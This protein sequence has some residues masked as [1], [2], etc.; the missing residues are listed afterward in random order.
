MVREL[1][2]DEL[3]WQCPED[4]LPASSTEEV[5]PCVGIIGQQRAITALEFG[6][7]V[8]SLGFN[9]F[10]TGLT[11]TGK[12]TAIELQL[13]P[14]AE[15][16]PR[17]DDL[18]YV[19]DFDRPERPR[20][21][22]LRAGGGAVLRE[23]LDRFLTQLTESLPGLFESEEY[24]RR[25]ELALED[26]KI[27]QQELVRAFEEEVRAHG[28]TLVQVQVGSVTRPEILPLVEN[29][30]VTMDKVRA[31]AAEGKIDQ[32]HL[33]S[34]EKQYERLS[35]EL[36]R[37]FAQ[38]MGLRAEMVG[39]AER[40]RQD[41]LRPVLEEQMNAI[42][43]AV[44]DERVAPFLTA[45]ASD[46]LKNLEILTAKREDGSA[47]P[48]TRYRVNVVVD[49]S[50]TQGR[51]VVIETEP[52]L[53]RLFGTIEARLGQDLRSSADHTQIRAGSLLRANGGFLVLNAFDVLSESG[54]WRA[55]KRALRYRRVAVRAPETLF[56][57]AGQALQPEPVEL[58][59]KVV[60]MGDRGLYD[61]LHELDDD[62]RKIFKVLS[63]FDNE[64]P[65]DRAAVGD[66]LSLMARIIREEQLPHLD[67]EGMAALVE[68]G[69]RLARTRRR[70]SARFS[71]VADILREAA[72]VAR[73]AE[74]SGISRAEVRAAVTQRAERNSLPEQKIIQA[75][76]EGLLR[77]AT[78][79][80]A[81]G[82][83][84][85]LAV[86]DLGYH[87]FGLPGRLSARV[88]LGREGVINIEREARL[89]GRTHDKG[90]LILTG[91]LRGLFA[92]EHPLSMSVSIA[93]EQTY[94]GVDG[95]SASSTEV[96]AILS[97]LSGLPLRQDVAVTG[98]VDQQGRVQAIGGVN[99]KIEGFFRLCR[100]RGLTGTQGVMIPQANIADL[101]LDPELVEEVGLGR[102]HIWAVA[103]VAEGIE[104]LTGVPAGERDEQG[105]YPEG[106]VLGRCATRLAAMAEQLRR[107][108][109]V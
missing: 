67:R 30:P 23:E 19:Y 82:E 31:L 57:L 92:V 71:D 15:R 34:L 3:R 84:N 1:G 100:A 4:W 9:V 85:G 26:L 101:Q 69:V 41:T 98:S 58:N 43:G 102:F 79:G 51:P 68:E 39:R 21:L 74:R 75:M 45:V 36:Q 55:L 81:V 6:L 27:R 18:L 13:Q 91:Y 29:R 76:Q 50:A 86:F 24:Q 105:R 10:V 89:S 109:E 78:A 12:M 42:A 5:E 96:Y 103:S 72:W 2:R 38:V 8:D 28:F 70:L 61:L 56:T 54:V 108:R 80:S 16:G 40:L 22:V 17:P 95:D 88:A 63:D 47:D 44:G 97:A 46:L 37:A 59:V 77:V 7:G 99:E 104:L 66:F 73:R 60:M 32:Q 53:A 11:G 93:F 94:G 62:F 64:T 49:N 90:V 25:L 20:L 65:L 35:E 83:V 14:H 52:T 106:T 87:A 107:Y 33:S 48:L